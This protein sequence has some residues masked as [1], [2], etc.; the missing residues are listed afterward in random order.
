MRKPVTESLE[1]N[2]YIFPLE[3][4][5]HGGGY[6][7][8]GVF[9]RVEIETVILARQ[10][11]RAIINILPVEVTPFD[12]FDN[13]EMAERNFIFAARDLN[14]PSCRLVEVETLNAARDHARR[15][16]G[17]IGVVIQW[18]YEDR[19]WGG[20]GK[21]IPEVRIEDFTI[22]SNPEKGVLS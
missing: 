3:L 10:P 5:R 4:V 18:H 19:Q 13:Y 17:R 6:A 12:D 15:K 8:N 14:F 9:Q 22:Y 7:L 11:A 20:D 1:F 16:G 21:T 2:F